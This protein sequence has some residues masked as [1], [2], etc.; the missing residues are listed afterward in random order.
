MKQLAGAIILVPGTAWA[1]ALPPSAILLLP[2]GH[3]ILGAALTVAITAFLGAFSRWLPMLSSRHL[4]SGPD[5]FPFMLTSYLSF[6]AFTG[7]LMIGVYGAT[8][9]VHNLLTLVIWTG[10]WIALPLASMIAGNLWSSLSPWLAPVVMVRALIGRT[11]SVGLAR[12]GH[13]PAVLGLWA[14]SWFQI[15]ST[16][17]DDPTVLAEAALIY[18]V[19]IFIAAVAEGEDWLAQG[20]FLTVFMGMIARIAPFWRVRSAGQVQGFIGWPGAQVI[21]MAALE[22]SEMAFVTLALAAL[23][24]DGLSGTF[25][26]L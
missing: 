14:F 13:W 17:P 25:F 18:W 12:F 7:L 8:D 20:E 5:R 10:V 16:A 9:P 1:C 22:I 11:T 15:I 6:L 2:T 21:G 26:W 19:L 4:F 23:T 24:F 3:Y